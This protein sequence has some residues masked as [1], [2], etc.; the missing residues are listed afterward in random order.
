[1]DHPDWEWTQSILGGMRHRL[2]IRLQDSI[3]CRSSASNAL[4][5]LEYSS[6]VTSFINTQAAQGF[7]LGPI[8][9]PQEGAGIVTSP[10]ATSY[11]ALVHHSQS[12]PS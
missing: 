5:A 10:L 9:N 4:S 6:Q 7:M 2:H 11:W 8:D 1:M 12:V 3:H